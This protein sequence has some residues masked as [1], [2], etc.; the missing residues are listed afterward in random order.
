VLLAIGVIH[1]SLIWSGDILT[2]YALVSFALVI[3]RTASN[4]QLVRWAAFFW[5]LGPALVLEVRWLAGLQFMV[6]TASLEYV[7]GHGSW[8]QI[9]QVRV[10][11]Y[12]QW[13]GRWGL[14]S[15]PTILAAFLMGLWSIKSGYARRVFERPSATA[16]LLL[17]AIIA[18]AIGYAS[19]A[20]AGRIWPAIQPP[21]E[22]QPHFPYP[23]FHLDQ[24]VL[25]AVRLVSW[26]TQGSS[27]VYACVL[28]LLWQRPRI[29]RFLRP[30]AA[31]GRM[32]L[33][34]YLTQS[35]V[36]TLLFYGYGLG[37]RV[38]RT[39]ALVVTVVVYACQM[40]VSM[41][42]LA[43]FRFGPAEWLWRTLTYGNVAARRT[44]APVLVADHST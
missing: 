38:G 26:S 7:L 8:L 41:W 18:A 23:Y 31:T 11:M 24:V 2:I 42:W 12:L 33:T 4:R 36:C 21:P 44:S 29:A 34:T 10:A 1:G 3:F 9:Q 19:D 14:L 17:I 43:R 35:V 6:Q 37:W 39:G 25:V 30:L 15:Y 16:K 40:A 13:L 20:Y 5:L 22:F 32:G 28:L 27:L